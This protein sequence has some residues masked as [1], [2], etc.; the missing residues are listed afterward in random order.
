M[1]AGLLYTPSVL[2]VGAMSAPPP[3]L[4]AQRAPLMRSAL[5]PERESR[6]GPLLLAASSHAP[7]ELGP[8]CGPPHA[9]PPYWNTIDVLPAHAWPAWPRVTAPALAAETR[10]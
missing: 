6:L 7:L 10:C 8:R 1:V 2:R 4:M 3:R 5:Q 9:A